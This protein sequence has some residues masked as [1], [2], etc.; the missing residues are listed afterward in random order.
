MTEIIQGCGF[1][2]GLLNNMIPLTNELIGKTTAGTQ[3]D[4]I[5]G[6]ARNDRVS[7]LMNSLIILYSI[8]F[9]TL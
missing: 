9:G 5:P 4:W 1:T 6:Q 2:Y 8:I 3:G 7:L